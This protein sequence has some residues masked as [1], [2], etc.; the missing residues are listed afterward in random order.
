MNL[1]DNDIILEANEGSV[2]FRDVTLGID[3]LKV[4]YAPVDP[5][6]IVSAPKG[7]IASGP[8]GTFTNTDGAFAWSPIGTGGTQ[9]SVFSMIG[10][11]LSSQSPP[12]PVPQTLVNLPA[13]ILDGAGR[14]LRVTWSGAIV[15]SD[16]VSTLASGLIF[17]DPLNPSNYLP[18]GSTAVPTVGH[19]FTGQAVITIRD[20]LVPSPTWG[21]YIAGSG[22]ASNNS[23]VGSGS[24]GGPLGGA[25]PL[26]LAGVV[27]FAFFVGF[28]GVNPANILRL[29]T[30]LVEALVP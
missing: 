30:F 25:T 24:G 22:A 3:R 4:F 11:V 27:P 21:I 23:N 2:V 19:N 18:T 29:D 26:P 20:P 5:N 7:S 8:A 14:A 28:S 10:P 9:P 6:G 17:G 1:F 12:G 15:N 13:G 16:G